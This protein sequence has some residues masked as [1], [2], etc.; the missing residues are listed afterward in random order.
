MGIFD[1]INV[2]GCHAWERNP[3]IDE[4]YSKRGGTSGGKAEDGGTNKGGM[5][6][7]DHM[8]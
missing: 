1:L 7:G 2:G 8:F 3:R 4:T 6:L 5:E